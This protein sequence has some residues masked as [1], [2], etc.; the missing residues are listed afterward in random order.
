M[1]VTSLF[2]LLSAYPI[3][4]CS[5][6]ALNTNFV[7]VHKYIH[8]YIHV[9]YVA[10]KTQHITRRHIVIISN[11]SIKVIWSRSRSYDVITYA[12]NAGCLAPSTENQSCLNESLGA[13]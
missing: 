10:G 7:L 11:F 1:P 9:Y 4:L 12:R 8:T 2:G 5:L 6:S 13:L 3:R